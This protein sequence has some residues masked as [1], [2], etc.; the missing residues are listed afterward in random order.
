GAGKGRKEAGGIPTQEGK[1]RQGKE[2]EEGVKQPATEA[3]APSTSGGVQ[4]KVQAKTGGKAKK[5][6]PQQVQQVKSQ[7]ANFRAEP[8]PQQ[9][10]AVT[11]NLN[12]RIEG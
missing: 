10:Q 1:E 5:P 4:Q 3:G 2:R 9:V 12:H 11:F 6:E 8:K 7:H